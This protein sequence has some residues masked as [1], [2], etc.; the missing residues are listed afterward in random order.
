VRGRAHEGAARQQVRAGRAPSV[1]YSGRT[2]ARSC[3]EGGWARTDHP[4]HANRGGYLSVALSWGR[5]KFPAGMAG[6]NDGG[7]S[8]FS[9]RE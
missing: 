4:R 8:L 5:G 6:A 1:G 7:Q 9:W 3:R 2:R